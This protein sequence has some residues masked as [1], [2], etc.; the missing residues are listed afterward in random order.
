M[1]ESFLETHSRCCQLRAAPGA[2]RPRS[3]TC[4]GAPEEQRQEPQQGKQ[5]HAL[6]AASHSLCTHSCAPASAC[7]LLLPALPHLHLLL[8]GGRSHGNSPTGGFHCHQRVSPQRIPSCSIWPQHS[9][10]VL[11]TEGPEKTG[12]NPSCVYNSKDSLGASAAEPSSQTCGRNA[13]GKTEP[14]PKVLKESQLEAFPK[15]VSEQAVI[16][17]EQEKT[18]TGK[19]PNRVQ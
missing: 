1:C 6:A 10:R 13:L 5:G 9:F 11:Q 3:L 2:E 16:P 15:E 8:K 17:E 18:Q 14:F 4:R 12:S 7:L 19:N